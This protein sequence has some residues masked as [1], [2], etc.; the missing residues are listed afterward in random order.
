MNPNRDCTSY[1][2]WIT[3]WVVVG[4]I[5]VSQLPAFDLAGTF[6]KRVN[7]LS[8]VLPRED[9]IPEKE[10]AESVFDTMLLAQIEAEALS[11]MD[12]TA[13]LSET[14]SGTNAPQ[15]QTQQSG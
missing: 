14:S 15:E 8:D 7:I 5:G 1:A 9:S 3:L 13:R 2:F 12:S 10:N 4:L 6:I 11:Q